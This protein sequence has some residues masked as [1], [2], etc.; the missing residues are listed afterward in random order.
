MCAITLPNGQTLSAPAGVPCGGITFTFKVFGNTFTLLLTV[1]VILALIYLILG[2]ITWIRSG[3]DKQKLA[4]ARAS[5]SYAIIGLI[6]AL[7]SFF[8]VN[9]IGFFFNVK[10]L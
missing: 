5:I 3:G 4:K 10:L 7:V 2:G 8:I 1:A 6:V 9:I